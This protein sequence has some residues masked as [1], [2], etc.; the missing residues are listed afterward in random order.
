LLGDD[1]PLAKSLAGYESRPGQLVMARAV[2]RALGEDRILLCEAGTGTGKTLAYLVPALLSGKK[3]VVSTAT[4]ALQEQIETRDLPL[5]ARHLGIALDVAV[6]KGLSN[7]VCLRRFDEYRRNP[8]SLL[9]ARAGALSLV[10]A[11]R[12]TTTSGDIA[13]LRQL[14]ESDPIWREVTSSSDTRV[15]PGCAHFD[16]CFV[17]RMKRRAESAQLVIVNHHLFFADLALRGP[18]P[19]HVIPDYD[20][21]IF[22]E[23]HQLED[24]ATDFFGVRVSSSRLE[25]L[26]RDLERVISALGASDSTL[27]S[28]SSGI[29]GSA[30]GAAAAFWKELGRAAELG[31]ANDARV[32]LE[33]DVWAG[34][35]AR[36]WHELDS[37]LEGVAALAES[38]R[39]RLVQVTEGRLPKSPGSLADALDV[40]G[41][42]TT[43][44]REQ[45]AIAIDGAPGRVTWVEAGAKSWV[46]SSSPVD[47]SRLFRELVFERVPAVVLTSATLATGSAAGAPTVEGSRPPPAS[48]FGYLRTRLGLTDGAL[49]V[50]EEVIA[51]PFDFPNNALFYT[52]ADLPE[53]GAPGFLDAAAERVRELVELSDGGVFVLTT[54]LRSM[55]RLAQLLRSML[56]GRTVLLQGEAPKSA[57]LEDFRERQDAVLVATQS[58]WE[59]VDIPGRALRVVVLEKIPFA[60]PTD[61]IVRARSLRIE[62]DG[63][64]A[65]MSLHVPAAAIALK[66]G[67][68]RLIRTRSDAGVVALF[69]S[70]VRTKSYGKR[71][72]ASLPP[73]QRTEQLED[74]RRF[75]QRR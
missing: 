22:D 14:S 27:A 53:P 7:Y 25:A 42:R 2:E 31:L 36:R 16:E 1:G 8:S 44:L 67:F 32:A 54:S 6:M 48:P 61:P 51:S 23:A 56:E 20:A 57:L 72:L 47:V 70:R 9:E 43:E 38:T 65:F 39:G 59:G 69:D 74:V 10:E 19:G 33:R 35:L 68:G 55:R 11:W 37:T 5:I 12:E 75:W 46:L 58:F 41:R 17:T 52:P 26:L 63:G 4:R 73:A 40:A 66:Q 30:R 15:G 71:L 34:E 18:H 62:A 28:G 60:V 64:N 13:S 24:I 50:H 49:E 45:L 21:V 29:I 3:V